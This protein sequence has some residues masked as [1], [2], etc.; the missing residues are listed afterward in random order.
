MELLQ[1]TILRM[2]PNIDMTN[3]SRELSDSLHLYYTDHDLLNEAHKNGHNRLTASCIIFSR[4]QKEVWMFGDCQCRIHKHTYT[5]E[6]PVDRQLAQIRSEIIH[7]LLK[8]GH[9]EQELRKND[10]GRMFIY[11][12]LMEQCSFQNNRSSGPYA[13]TVIDGFPILKEHIPVFS[14]PERTEVILASDGYP[15]LFDSWKETEKYLQKIL[16]DDPLCISLNIA[17]KGLNHGQNSFDDRTY[18]R[19]IT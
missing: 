1:E 19:F 9:T 3:A 12:A 17:T 13:Y 4:K 10:L 18:I 15:V 2:S 16:S 14:V 11:Q 5:N 8:Q 7:Y 6:K